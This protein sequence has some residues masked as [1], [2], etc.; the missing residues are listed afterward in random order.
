MIIFNIL[1]GTEIGNQLF[2]YAA[3]LSIAKKLNTELVLGTWDCKFSANEKRDYYLSRS[4]F[5]G[6]TER[7]ANYHDIKQIIS[8]SAAIRASVENFIAYKPIRRHHIFRRLLRKL[9]YKLTPPPL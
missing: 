5:P 9:F 3:G 8:T 1:G 6:I 2:F 4:V 7:E